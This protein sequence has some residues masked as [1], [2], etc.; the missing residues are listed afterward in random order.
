[1][2]DATALGGYEEVHAMST[3]ADNFTGWAGV[4]QLGRRERCRSGLPRSGARSTSG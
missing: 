4:Q 2:I 3:H 1:M